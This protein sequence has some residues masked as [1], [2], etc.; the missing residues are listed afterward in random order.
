MP[1]LAP[2]PKRHAPELDIVEAARVALC[3][4]PG[5]RVLPNRSLLAVPWAMRL[6]PDAHPV[7][8]GLGEGSADLVGIVS[9]EIPWTPSDILKLGRVFVLEFKQPGARP[10]DAKQR[11]HWERQEAWLACVRSF[12]GY[13]AKVRTVGEA[14]ACVQRCRDLESGE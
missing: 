9:L 6:N 13:A 1:A 10:R 8:V 12:G 11:Q 7:P 2:R 14:I 3:A 4:I 5:V